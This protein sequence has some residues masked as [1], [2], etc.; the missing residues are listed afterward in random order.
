MPGTG[1]KLPVAFSSEAA[2]PG[3]E[4][5]DGAVLCHHNPHEPNGGTVILGSPKL[6]QRS[7]SSPRITTFEHVLCFAFESSRP[8]CV[9]SAA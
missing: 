1:V 3:S 9:L 6:T 5:R 7:K 2:G 4:S 8:S